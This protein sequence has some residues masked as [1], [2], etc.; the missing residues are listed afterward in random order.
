M[1]ARSALSVGLAATIDDDRL[2]RQAVDEL[3]ALGVD[4]GGVTLAPAAGRLVVV[5]AVG[6]LSDVRADAGP[7]RDFEIPSAWSAPVLLLSG[8]SP[9]TSR[10]AALCKAA[11]RARRAGTCVV[12][13]VAAGLREWAGRDARTLSMVVREA[14]VVRS[15]LRNL[16]VLGTDAVRLRDAMRAGATLVVDDAGRTTAAGPFGE[17]TVRWAAPVRPEDATDA[18]TAAICAQLA[19]PPR[20]AASPNARWHRMLTAMDRFGLATDGRAPGE[21]R[22]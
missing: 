5:D 2:G 8:V 20:G 3:A 11:R 18:C 22:R 7:E 16:A 12:L 15:S 19:R 13:D 21:A 10:A 1:L 6:G 14:D 9:R 17:V 4:V